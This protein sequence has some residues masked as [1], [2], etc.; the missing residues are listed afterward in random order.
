[1]VSSKTDRCNFQI[2][3]KRQSINGFGLYLGE[4]GP[5]R[6]F[7][8]ESHHIMKVSTYLSRFHLEAL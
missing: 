6:T 4:N 5:E 8:V 2:K 7:K 1:M 3:L